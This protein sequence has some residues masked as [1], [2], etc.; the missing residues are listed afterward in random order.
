[1]EQKIFIK[2]YFIKYKWIL[3][4]AAAIALVAGIFSWQKSGQYSVSQSIIVSR[5]GTQQANDYKFDSYYAIQAS[6]DFCDMVAGIFKTPEMA[7]NVY[8]KAGLSYSVNSLGSLARRFSSSKIAPGVVEVRFG[9]SSEAEANKISQAVFDAAQ[10]KISMISSASLQGVSFIALKNDPVIAKNNYAVW[11]S[12][13]A[14]FLAGLALGF[15][16]LAAKKYL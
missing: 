8:K 5:L 13:L 7:A 16:V 3:V 4:F 12:V 11:L 10:E 9:A 1:M 14:G 15:F 6:D 2:Q